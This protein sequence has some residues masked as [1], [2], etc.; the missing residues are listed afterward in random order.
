MTMVDTLE[1][2]KK[3]HLTN[4][5]QAIL[6]IINNNTDVLVNE[7]IMFLFRKPPLD[8]MDFIKSK[9]LDLA[10]KN[11]VILDIIK[12]DGMLD[13][14]RKDIV[15]CCDKI[16]KIRIDAL[17]KIVNSVQF[18]KE[19][20]VI[21]FNKKDFLEINKNLKKLIK[22]QLQKSVEEK[23]IKNI[24]CSLN[25]DVDFSIKKKFSDEISKFVKGAYQRQLLESIDFKLLVKDTTLAN[26]A[27]ERAE[28]HLFTLANSRLFKQE[29]N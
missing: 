12:L 7:D 15:K 27:K 6:E 2:F 26:S 20:E 4:Y 17:K 3:Q 29:E 28:R 14:Y 25:D 23:I 19:T 9:Y 13:E 10:K 5:K 16:K 8:S 22:E 18:D 24:L 21:K 11:K 1:E